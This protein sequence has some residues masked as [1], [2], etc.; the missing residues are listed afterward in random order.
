MKS[1]EHATKSGYYSRL[2]KINKDDELWL[3]WKLSS[4]TTDGAPKYKFVNVYPNW[5]DA[6]ERA[7]AYASL[8]RFLG[9]HAPE[10]LK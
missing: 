2:F 7:E 8:Y 5:L 4:L 3:L 9:L 1:T 6:Y 10:D